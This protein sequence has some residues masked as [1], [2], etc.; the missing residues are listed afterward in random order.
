[1]FS[2]LKKDSKTPDDGSF[3]LHFDTI[4]SPALL[5]WG[6]MWSLTSDY[7]DQQTFVICYYYFES[8]KVRT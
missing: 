6:L 7:A 8:I 4:T 1:M 5:Q 2:S 3:I